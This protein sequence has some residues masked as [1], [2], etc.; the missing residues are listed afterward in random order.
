LRPKPIDRIGSRRAG[1]DTG[2]TFAFLVVISAH[3]DA[4]W[5]GAAAQDGP[6]EQESM[7]DPAAT[8]FDGK[9]AY[10]YLKHLTV[11]IGARLTG[12]PGEHRAARYLRKLFQSFG[13]RAR[14]QKFPVITFANRQCTFEVR[15][16]N[17]WRSLPVQPVMMTKNTPPK[18]LEGEIYYA[19]SGDPEY[20]SPEMKDKIV[21]VCGGI[22][23]E[24]RPRL[25]SYKPKAL[26]FVEGGITDEPLRMNI[27]DESR[28]EFGN[29]PMARI[30]HLDGVDI[31][32]NGVRRGRL[33]MRN[34]ERKSFG[35]NVIA[36]KRGSD[37]P[38]D[39]IVLCAHYDTSM[40]ITGA[41]DNAGGTSILLELA[42]VL[43]AAPTKRTLRFI[44]FAAEETGLQGSRHYANRLFKKAERE[45]KRKG[46]R[47]KV[48]KT[49]LDKHR[50]VF[51]L[52]VHGAVIGRKSVMFSGHDDIGASVRLL[53]K[54]IGIGCGVIK[55]PMASDGTSLAA[56]GVPAIQF[57]RGGG[58]N[59][60]LHSSLDDI[61][62]ISPS[63]LAKAGRFAE[64]YLRRYVTD[65]AAFPFAREVPEDQMGNIKRMFSG[66]RFPAPGEK[67]PKAKRRAAPK[68]KRRG[69]QKPK[70]RTRKK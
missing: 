64:L 35:L 17:K 33:V 9:K 52:D 40:G 46:F 14:F 70:R 42:R 68:A 60:Y 41:L 39:I 48:D 5:P 30:R 24:S 57:E 49:E 11:D 15:A 59:R 8:S 34:T 56:V 28:K 3:S 10:R 36:E 31:L 18:G 67:K 50:L 13:L 25:L 12:S 43:G 45:K 21:M 27:T 1:P 51:N 23:T 62:H 37:F 38:E 6:E 7:T 47:E 54:E 29:L 19:E 16:G 58:T 26:V 55:G 65:S 22:G 66:A 4:H 69:T 20:L 44:G 63:S 2:K 53:A 32:K 61:S